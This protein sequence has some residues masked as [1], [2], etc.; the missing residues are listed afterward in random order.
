MDSNTFYIVDYSPK[1]FAI[2]AEYETALQEEFTTIGGRFNSRLAFGAGW[3]FS[4]KKHEEQI[5][6]LFTAYGIEEITERVKLS[7]IATDPGKKHGKGAKTAVTLPDYILPDAERKKWITAAH[8]E[9]YIKDFPVVVQLSE[10]VATINLG[11]LETEFWFGYSDY[12]QG[13]TL[14]E[15][16]NAC[17]A[18]QTEEYFIN[19]NTESLRKILAGLKQETT[20]EYRYLILR[21]N[22]HYR[23]PAASWAIH[24]TNVCPDA[25]NWVETM[26]AYDRCDYEKG[27]LRRITEEERQRLIDGYTL[28]LEM[29]EK[30]LKRYLKRFGTSKLR[31]STYWID[32]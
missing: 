16:Y 20:E 32:R 29:Q 30:R 27:R 22:N 25:V 14:E 5:N 17:K 24:W 18:A 8:G 23:T 3:I 11:G 13:L 4:K 28:A 19:K 1:A 9:D 15:A 12:G 10:G 21:R 7:D 26:D 6:G 31:A 2:A